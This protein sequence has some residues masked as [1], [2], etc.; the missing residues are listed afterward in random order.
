LNYLISK[1]A[2]DYPFID[3]FMF[4]RRH[5]LVNV[6]TLALAQLLLGCNREQAN[7]KILILENSIPL[8]LIGDFKAKIAQSKLFTFQ[9]ES[10]LKDLYDLLKVWQGKLD[11]R[12]GLHK[13]LPFLPGGEAPPVANL[14]SLG[15]AWLANAIAEGSLEPLSVQ[16]LPGWNQLPTTWQQLVKRNNKGELDPN[17]AIW[18]APYRWGTTAIAYRSDKIED[19]G[20]T[21]TDWSDLWREECTGRISLLDDPREVIGLTLKK[22]GR[23]YNTKN[24]SEVANLKTE[25]QALNQQAKLYS[26]DRYLEPLIIGDTWVAVGWSTDFLSL[27]TRYPNIKVTVPRSGTALWNDL[28]V[29]PKQKTQP[30]QQNSANLKQWI[31][32][33][34]ETNSA[35][36]ISLFTDA[37]SPIIV[38]ID[39]N[40]LP[41]DIRNNSLL[42]PESAILDQ[43]EF[44]NPLPP[45]SLKQYQDLWKEIRKKGVGNR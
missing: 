13:T 9:P 23:S 18:G 7:L 28:W 25:L 6:T 33:C 43:C 17:G 3:K 39:R 8:Q 4:N 44:L 34:W 41:T 32:F 37:T 22:L 35:I 14:I 21:P 12:D 20:W 16:N 27:K 31:D 15:D 30:E 40:Q 1:K 26:S 24:L 10:Q 29:Q 42:L 11:N 19:W 2:I 5:F 36:E 38:K 45:E